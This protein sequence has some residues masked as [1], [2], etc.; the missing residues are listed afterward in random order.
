MIM[1]ATMKGSEVTTADDPL[2]D[3]DD[4]RTDAEVSLP[5]DVEE[6]VR[7]MNIGFET[8]YFSIRDTEDIRR[9]HEEFGVPEND[10]PC[11]P[12]PRQ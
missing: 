5:S 12:Q 3:M 6:A 10:F 9:V 4:W 8:G 7:M 1:V 11:V 2:R